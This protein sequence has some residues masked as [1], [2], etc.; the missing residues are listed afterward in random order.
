MFENPFREDIDSRIVATFG[1]IGT[2][3]IT[4]AGRLVTLAFRCQI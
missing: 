2:K 1:E 3:L 4:T